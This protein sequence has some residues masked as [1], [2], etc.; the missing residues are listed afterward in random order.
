MQGLSQLEKHEIGDVHQVVFG[1]NARSP[2]AVLHPFGRRAY[3]TILD[4]NTRIA[5][6]GF[7][8]FHLHVDLQI[9]V[10]DGESAHVGPLQ[11]D[12][13]AL[14]FKIGRQITCHAD[15]RRR[16]DAVGSQSDADDIVVFQLQVLPGRLADFRVGR[17]LHDARMRSSD[18]QFVLGAE[19]PERLHAPD[20]AALDLE[21]LL[22]AVGVEHRTHRSAKDLETLP[23][24]GSTADDLQRSLAAYIHRRQ[25]Q[26]VRIGMIRAGQHLADH[27]AG[28]SAANRFDL[29]EALDLQ[30]DIG[31]D[32]RH[33]FGRQIGFKV[34]FQPVIG[35]IHSMCNILLLTKS[36]Q[37]YKNIPI[38][39]PQKSGNYEDGQHRARNAVERAE[40]DADIPLPCRGHQQ[41]FGDEDQREKPFAEPQ[42]AVLG[43]KR[44]EPEK[45]R[46][47]HGVQ[48]NTEQERHPCRK[49]GRDG[50]KAVL[51]VEIGVL[52][53]I[54]DVEAT[55][56]GHHQQRQDTGQLL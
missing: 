20:L 32:R 23:T 21:L 52:Q 46:D 43:A 37:R 51:A 34:A 6:C 35:D 5:R 26:M 8:V 48:Q 2:Q 53:R 50:V 18:T 19:H 15:M 39:S 56:P 55:A 1:G 38:L 45:R 24:V 54:D 16:V 25:M 40:S 42:P 7:A 14:A 13:L 12:G 49:T 47:A 29:F 17:Q 28:K 4:R 3:L 30:A 41:V 27:D 31:E 36:K 10:I 44:S 22:A 9:V 11:L 33:F